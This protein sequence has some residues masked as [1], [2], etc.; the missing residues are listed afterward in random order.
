MNSQ[1][2][3]VSARWSRGGTHSTLAPGSKRYFQGHLNRMPR[4]AHQECVAGVSGHACPGVLDLCAVQCRV[5]RTEPA[6]SDPWVTLRL[7]PFPLLPVH[8]L[9]WHRGMVAVRQMIWCPS[10]IHR[11]RCPSRL[12]FQTRCLGARTDGERCSR[13]CSREH[14]C[15]GRACAAVSIHRFPPVTCDGVV[16]AMSSIVVYA[17]SQVWCAPELANGPSWTDGGGI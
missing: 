3:R 16:S 9:D 14:S 10:F 11:L 8:Q 4:W 17:P 2:E 6:S 1:D 7:P 5:G 15:R 13:V 12:L